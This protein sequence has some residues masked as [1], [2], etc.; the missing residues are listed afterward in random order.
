M[1][2]TDAPGTQRATAAMIW[3]VESLAWMACLFTD[4]PWLIAIVAL[5]VVGGRA[6]YRDWLV[7]MTEFAIA[8]VIELILRRMPSA[9]RVLPKAYDAALQGAAIGGYT[10][11]FG[12]LPGLLL[13]QL[14]LG[15]DAEH[16]MHKLLAMTKQRMMPRGIRLVAGILLVLAYQARAWL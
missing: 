16:R 9:N 10:I 14:S 11:L 15:V 6:F 7:V 13:W 5:E 4:G 12:T 3:V 8:I 1:S 2:D